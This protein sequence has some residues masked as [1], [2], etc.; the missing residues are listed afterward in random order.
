MNSFWPTHSFTDRLEFAPPPPPA[1]LRAFALALFVHALLL[2]AL[3]WGINWKSN[4]D[5]V[6][7]EA[8]L[9]ASVPR[10][11]APKALLPPLPKAPEPKAEPRPEP[12]PAEATKAADIALE[13]EKLRREQLE[14]ERLQRE[15][16][17]QAALAKKQQQLEAQRLQARVVQEEAQKLEQQRKENLKRIAGL[18]DASGAANASGSALQSAGPSAGYA[19]RIRARIKPNIVFA[20]DTPGNPVADVEVRTAPDGSIVARK[21]L[22]SSGV[23]GWDDA[24]LKAI[25]KTEV[26]PRDID[27]RVPS[28]LVISFRPKD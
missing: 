11:A 26:L 9:W 15:L 27:G 4:S 19:A 3:A 14:L 17:R 18:A 5:T 20:D 10:P 13:K 8:E 12:Q 23:T 16:E 6:A 24:V 28:T 21:L 22:K 25:D 7:V 2:L 1:L